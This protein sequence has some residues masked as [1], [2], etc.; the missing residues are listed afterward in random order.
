MKWS[1]FLLLLAFGY[2]SAQS[3]ERSLPRRARLDPQSVISQYR[4]TPKG[5]SPGQRDFV[6]G[7]CH[8]FLNEEDRAIGYFR[9]AHDYF[10][11]RR[12]T[13]A[14]V[15]AGL[16]A[17]RIISSVEDYERFGK[18]YLEEYRRYAR[19]SGSPRRLAICH[20]E[21]AANTA[22]TDPTPN[23][24]A[25][26]YSRAMAYAIAANDPDLIGR[27]HANVGKMWNDF[28][29]YGKARAALDRSLPYVKASGDGF[30]LFAHHF[31]YGNSYLHQGAYDR[32]LAWFQKAET[33]PLAYYQRRSLR[34]LY[35]KIETAADSLGDENLRRRYHQ[36]HKALNEALNDPQHLFPTYAED[37]RKEAEA[38]DR[39]ISF[40]K[41]L[42]NRFDRH[43]TVFS[44]LLT[45]VFVL[46]LY[47]FI[48]WKKVDR[49][50]R[51]LERSK[52]EIEI[53]HSR[54]VEQ[55]EKVSQL[56]I[57]DHIV[58]KNHSKLYLD[59]LM[60]IKADDHYLHFVPVEGKPS[61]LRGTLAEIA[62]GL[63]PNFRRSHRSY[64]VNLNF[65]KSANS[66]A[67]ILKN[68]EALPVSRGFKL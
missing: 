32:A 26:H 42:K 4:T 65:V 23:R 13:A 49:N 14:A 51:K 50:R 19:R 64:I 54:T 28:G 11:A 61:F 67:I 41:K 20:M 27:I 47:S 30:R 8:A 44:A 43:R 37:Q 2:G 35:E 5:I 7:K 55:L 16:E 52:Q 33:V 17:Y 1:L 68:N 45:A 40:L 63:P 6:L 46:A 15:D 24:T 29:Q 59:K 22:D 60:Y 18:A 62:D 53:E 66:R 58:L 38:K 21:D 12:D 9:R 34:K 10:E 57:E 56:V 36:K 48:R 3:L 31:N 25:A 39:E